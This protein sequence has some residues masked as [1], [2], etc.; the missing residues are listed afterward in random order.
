VRLEVWPEMIQVWHAFGGQLSAARRAIAAAGA[1]M[2]GKLG[3]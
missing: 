2:D 1:W 3:G